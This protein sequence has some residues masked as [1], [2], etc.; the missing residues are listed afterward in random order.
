MNYIL[1]NLVHKVYLPIPV[2]GSGGV[3]SFLFDDMNGISETMVFNS[4]SGDVY[5]ISGVKVTGT[6]QKGLYIINGKKV[7][8]R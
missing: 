7:V 1:N 4:T 8:I 5:T 6:L 3:S 2:S